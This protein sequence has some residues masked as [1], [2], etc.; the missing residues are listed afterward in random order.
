MWKEPVTGDERRM[1][2]VVTYGEK[3]KEVIELK[4][5]RGEEYHRDGLLQLSEYLDF[6]GMKQGYILIFDFNKTKQY[7]S[8]AIKA[9]GKDFFAVW[10]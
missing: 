5:W 6:Q 1:D 3:Q 8:E 10:I 4:I 2:I 9:N 7:K